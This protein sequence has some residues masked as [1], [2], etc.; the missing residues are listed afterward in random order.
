MKERLCLNNCRNVVPLP[1]RKKKI[2]KK[3]GGE[4]A[5]ISTDSQRAGTGGRAL[6]IHINQNGIRV[7]LAGPFYFPLL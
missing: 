2:N 4:T 3:K 7:S 6:L 5:L 1:P